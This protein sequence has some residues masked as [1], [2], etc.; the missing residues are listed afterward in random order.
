MDRRDRRCA[1]VAGAVVAALLLSACGLASGSK[2]VPIRVTVT[3]DFGA[4]PVAAVSVARGGSPETVQRL[5]K[6]SLNARFAAD[7]SIAS[8]EG[9]SAAQAQRGWFAFINGIGTS[10]AP[11]ALKLTKVHSGDSVWW[12]LHDATASSSAR[13]V[14]GA[15]PEPFEHGIS[16]RKLPTTIECAKNVD[17]A[18]K[19]VSSTLSGDGVKLA[20]QLLGTGSGQDSL[21]VVVGTWSELE[22][23]LV[24]SIVDHG[25]SA[26]GIYA[27]FVDGGGS[28]QLLDG[29]GRVV[30]TLG[31][32]AGLVAATRDSESQPTWLITGTDA[33]GVTAAARAV[34]AADLKR[35]FAVA[36]D[37]G[38]AIAL[39]AR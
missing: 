26:S 16:G 30:R 1:A 9:V 23:Q 22:P 35:R 29:S 12:D 19:Q 10:T 11:L 8:I 39:P 15:Y 28:L 17:S 25:P 32:G 37:D 27:R 7:G 24:G 33:A 34:N 2:N 36:V 14:V 13:A 6:R 18:C 31:G 38:S 3:R 21:G 20:T 4:R 5:L